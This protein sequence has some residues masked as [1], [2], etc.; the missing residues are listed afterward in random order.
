MSRFQQSAV[1]CNALNR[2][3][4][5]CLTVGA[6][7]QKEPTLTALMCGEVFLPA[8]GDPRGLMLRS[9]SLLT[10]HHCQGHVPADGLAA[11]RDGTAVLPCVAGLHCREMKGETSAAGVLGDA[12][13]LQAFSCQAAPVA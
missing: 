6:Y 3:L 12:P 4:V 8:E 7:E 2:E 10:C 5:S 1:K 11:D 9:V 13:I